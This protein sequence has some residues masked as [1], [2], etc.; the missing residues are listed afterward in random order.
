VALVTVAITAK[1][2]LKSSREKKWGTELTE[3]MMAARTEDE[4]LQALPTGRIL[5]S[6]PRIKN[7]RHP[8]PESCITSSCQGWGSEHPH[9]KSYKTSLCRAGTSM[10]T[11][12]QQGTICCY[13]LLSACHCPLLPETE[14]YKRCQGLGPPLLSI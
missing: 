4:K 5:G 1:G 3:T 7:L 12:T 10:K 2:Q 14:D 6:C 8:R 11:V 9:P 13:I